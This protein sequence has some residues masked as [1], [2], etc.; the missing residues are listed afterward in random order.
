MLRPD[1]AFEFKTT[2]NEQP[3]DSSEEFVFN[4]EVLNKKIYFT[5][6]DFND[7]YNESEI[8]RDENKAE[9]I[10]SKFSKYTTQRGEILEAL[11]VREIE[12]SD[13]LGDSAYTIKTLPYDD[14]INH[15][16]FVIEW[17]DC[18]PPIRLAIDVTVSE[19]PDVLIK[20]I[21]NIKK[22]LST[23]KGTKIKYFNSEETKQKMPLA[24]IPR[25]IIGL[26]KDNLKKLCK[27]QE[28][29]YSEDKKDIK[30][31][32]QELANHSLQISL[33]NQ[34]IQSASAQI[35]YLEQN[36]RNDTDIYKN[37][38]AVKNK[39]ELIL[40]NKKGSID[41]NSRRAMNVIDINESF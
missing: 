33:I 29:T 26:S 25:A 2:Y 16:D 20:K 11:L 7:T 34:L 23:G 40:D 18:E 3:L 6:K 31:G 21:R 12:L 22:E 4:I 28:K 35:Q 9:N 27:I 41:F 24:N 36:D 37:L 1:Q 32:N 30:S 15:T 38:L 14:Y 19:D 17:C 5:Y 8:K 39:L 10:K 13:W